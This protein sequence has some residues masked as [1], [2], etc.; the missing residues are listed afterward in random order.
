MDGAFN[1]TN[2]ATRAWLAG[3]A[4]RLA[5]PVTVDDPAE[6]RARVGRL[7]SKVDGRCTAWLDCPGCGLDG[8]PYSLDEAGRLGGAH[9]DLIHRGQ[10]AALVVAVAR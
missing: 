6:L 10:P 5:D 8:G 9:D 7:A 4:G 2:T 3:A 1:M